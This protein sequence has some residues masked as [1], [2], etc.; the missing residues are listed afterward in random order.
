MTNNNDDLLLQWL[1]E[2]IPLDNN[3]ITDEELSD[4]EDNITKG[5]DFFSV[6]DNNPSEENIVT[7]N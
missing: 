5:K 1:N 3:E 7:K 4:D 2:E 6:I